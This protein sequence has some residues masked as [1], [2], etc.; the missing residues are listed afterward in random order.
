MGYTT[1]FDGLIAIDP[2]LNHAERE[3]LN[4]FATTRRMNRTNGPY[5][6]HGSEPH[7]QG[8]DPDII[9]YNEPPP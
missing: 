5:F 8:R 6:V 4:R 1:Y 9:D 2:P 3:Y 7:G